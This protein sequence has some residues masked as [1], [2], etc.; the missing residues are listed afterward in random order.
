MDFLRAAS[1]FALHAAAFAALSHGLQTG[2]RPIALAAMPGALGPARAW[3]LAV[4]ARGGGCGHSA[5]SLRAGA[6]ATQSSA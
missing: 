3:M 2:D 1:L 5:A 4:G 6:L